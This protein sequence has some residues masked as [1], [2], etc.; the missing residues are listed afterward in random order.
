MINEGL[1]LLFNPDSLPEE[2]AEWKEYEQDAKDEQLNIWEI[3]GGAFDET[4]C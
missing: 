2:L 3:G 1:A 4:E